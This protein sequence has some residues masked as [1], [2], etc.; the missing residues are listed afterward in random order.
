[1]GRDEDVYEDANQFKPVRWFSGINSDREIGQFDEY[2]FPVFQAGYRI[3][4]GKELALYEVKAF[5]AWLLLSYRVI[6]K[7]KSA[8]EDVVEGNMFMRFSGPLNVVL[9][10]REIT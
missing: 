6:Y 9:E 8:D 10:R 5:F 1:M 4:A 3:C 2:A 7:P